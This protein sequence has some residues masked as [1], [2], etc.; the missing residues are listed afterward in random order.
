MQFSLKVSKTRVSTPDSTRR[1]NVHPSTRYVSRAIVVPA[2]ALTGR[3]TGR[4]YLLAIKTQPFSIDNSPFRLDQKD[5]NQPKFVEMPLFY[6]YKVKRYAL[7]ASIL[8]IVSSSC[9]DDHF[10]VLNIEIFSVPL[11]CLQCKFEKKMRG[12]KFFSSL[13][14][15]NNR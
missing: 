15:Y 9:N 12:T 7:L 13:I 14:N 4:F 1:L 10:G 2:M 8:T 11:P 6:F 3:Y 5:K